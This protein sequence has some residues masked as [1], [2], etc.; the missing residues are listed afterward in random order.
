MLKIGNIAQCLQIW[1]ICHKN[2]MYK[3]YLYACVFLLHVCVFI[4]SV[5]APSTHEGHK[6][7]LISLEPELWRIL[8][9]ISSG[10]C[11]L[12]LS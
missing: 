5:T 10:I 11:T 12:V 8:Y 7:V 2:L 4:I 3:V 1:M 9:H 6:R